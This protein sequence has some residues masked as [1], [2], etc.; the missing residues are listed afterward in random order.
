MKTQVKHFIAGL[1]VAIGV[2]ALAATFNQFSPATGV[3]KGNAST[4]VTTAA[5]SSD[6]RAMWSG[7]CDAT[8]FLRGDGAC[9]AAA[10]GTVTSVGLSMPTGFSVA[11]SPVTSS[12]TLAVTTTL[13][14]VLHGNGSGFS[15]SNVLLGSEVSGTLPVG[16]G[17]T[18]ATTLT[19]LVLGNGT[20][21]FTAYAG[22]T[23]TNQFVRSLNASGVATCNTVSLTADVTGT[24]PFGNGGTGL[25]TAADDTTLV[26]SGSAWVASALPNC[27]SSNQA[28]AY[29]TSTNSFSCQTISTGASGANPTGTVGLAAVNGVAT[30][31]LR[32]DGAPP[33]SQSI[34]PTWTGNH[35]YASNIL[36]SGSRD[37]GATGSRWLNIYASNLCDGTCASAALADSSGTTARFGNGSSWT[38]IS[39]PHPTTV[40]TSVSAPI[41][42]DSTNFEFLQSSGTSAIISGGSGWT[43]SS[44]RASTGSIN[45]SANGVTI[46]SPT[47]GTQGAGTINAAGYYINGV[48]IA[49]TVSGT[50]TANMTGMTGA[51]S[52]TATYEKIGNHIFLYLPLLSGTS[53]AATMTITGLP[54]AIQ[55]A[56]LTQRVFCAG[57]N[58]GTTVT[59]SCQ[60][61]AGSGTLTME[62]TYGDGGATWTNSGTKGTP[63]AQTISYLAN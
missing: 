19:G 42:Q 2:P 23:C 4:F 21:P 12:G 1:L 43:A 31:F 7:S 10:S 3:L 38:A 29:S 51:V 39:L 27:G 25:N 9:A 58:S 24:L 59:G 18:G 22:S 44:L 32:S 53:N 30:T 62:R 35:T 26:S 8:T 37:I 48:A 55:P 28:L 16:N 5:V 11:G 61:S 60:L 13:N 6:I 17:G 15:A 57:V 40:T 45:V 33:L 41:F 46:N 54:A 34:T 36:V 47:G 50:F 20:S 49:A 52:G 14:G 56:T 63:V